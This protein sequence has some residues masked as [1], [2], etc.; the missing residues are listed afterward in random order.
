MSV[1][2]TSR[3]DVALTAAD[4]VEVYISTIRTCEL[5][6]YSFLLLFAEFSSKFVY[7]HVRALPR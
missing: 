2:I 7:G 1:N 5:V 3:T 4:F 6:N